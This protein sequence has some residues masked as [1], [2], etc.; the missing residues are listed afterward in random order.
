M[1]FLLY[2]LLLFEVTTADQVIIE[3]PLGLVRGFETWYDDR[4]ICT[5]VELP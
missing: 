3:T 5:Q 1:D 4:N 2:F